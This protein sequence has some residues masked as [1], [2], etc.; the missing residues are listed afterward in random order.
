MDYLSGTTFV[1]T[2]VLVSEEGS[3]RVRVKMRFEDAV[4]LALKME[5]GVTGQGMQIVFR[6]RERQGNGF[7][8]RASRRN[9]A[10]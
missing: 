5:E 1:I 7:P 6:S 2:G 9:A 3:R 10:C 4:M 8:P